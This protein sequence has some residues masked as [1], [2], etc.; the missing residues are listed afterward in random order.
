MIPRPALPEREW[1]G[2]SERVGV[3][4]LADGLMSLVRVAQ[5]NGPHVCATHPCIVTGYGGGERQAGLEG[6]DPRAAQDASQLLVLPLKNG[7]SY[8]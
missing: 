5:S 3:K 8:T 4:P 7:S 6:R 1:L 2:S